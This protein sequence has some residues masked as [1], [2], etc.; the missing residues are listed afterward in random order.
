MLVLLLAIMPI[1]VMALDLGGSQEERNSI[2]YHFE[3][4]IELQQHLEAGT[5]NVPRNDGGI[6]VVHSRLSAIAPPSYENG[7]F[8]IGV[9]FDIGELGFGDFDE[10][11]ELA[12]QLE[13]S[14][15]F[16]AL[17]LEYTGMRSDMVDI[18][19]SVFLPTPL[20]SMDYVISDICPV[21][22][23]GRPIETHESYS[24]DLNMAASSSRV[25]HMG[26]M[27]AIGNYGRVTVGHPFFAGVGF[28]TAI[29]RNI[30]NPTSIIAW[31]DRV[32]T[33]IPSGTAV[34]FVQR[35]V[36]NQTIDITAV[37]QMA[38]G[39]STSFRLPWGGYAGGRRDPRN[40]DPV[41]SIR[42][43][44]GV[45]HAIIS[46]SHVFI[47]EQ[48]ISSMIATQPLGAAQRGDS[49]AA[50]I[51]GINNTVRGTHS[52]VLFHNGV[53]MGLYSSVLNY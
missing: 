45:Q 49:G 35:S 37:G 5:L 28:F 33:G 11:A 23:D 1:T 21:W 44:S 14:E 8:M 17:I 31:A 13:V 6:S 38:T 4:L 48:N 53:W 47:P 26:D 43:M 2:E 10:I 52:G 36:Y 46:N 32:Q 40:G 15:D 22:G 39:H 24:S 25:L 12:Q 42:G 7:R 50:L 34:G 30:A 20:L 9:A 3:R 51:H 29:H 27:V 41:S 16:I 18:G 19:L